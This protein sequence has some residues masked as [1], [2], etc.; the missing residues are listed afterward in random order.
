MERA[1][2]P[3]AIPWWG[4]KSHHRT[5]RQLSAAFVFCSPH[6][7]RASSRVCSKQKTRSKAA[8][9]ITKLA[10]RA[11]FEPAI[12]F[13]VYTLSRRAPSTTRTPLQRAANVQFPHLGSEYFLGILCRNTGYLPRRYSLDIRQF[14]H[15]ILQIAAFISLAPER[16]RAEI[17][18][19]RLQY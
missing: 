9:A 6:P 13:R 16:Y 3:P 19:I 18:R 4:L 7:L 17:G 10:E 8:G 15:Y 12:P 5:F 1:G 14:G 2:L 11:G